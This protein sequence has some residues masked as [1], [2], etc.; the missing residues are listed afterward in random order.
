MPANAFKQIVSGISKKKAERW[1]IRCI[2]VYVR[3]NYQEIARGNNYLEKMT[4][5]KSLTYFK[6]YLCKKN[7]FL[8]HV[9]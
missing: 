6:K 7:C 4:L 2:H 5:A 1:Y 8:E 9:Q 3:L